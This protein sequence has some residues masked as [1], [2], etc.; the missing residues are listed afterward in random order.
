[1]PMTPG[2]GLLE[3]VEQAVCRRRAIGYP[4]MLKSTAGGSGIGLTRC[5]DEAALREA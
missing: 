2:T 1:M 5:D 4:V 3:S